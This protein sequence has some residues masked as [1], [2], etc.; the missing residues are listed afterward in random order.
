MAVE[1]DFVWL[2]HPETG[3]MN[4][5]PPAA[6]PMWEVRGWV[7]CDPPAEDLSYLRDPGLFVESEPAAAPEH[8]PALEAKAVRRRQTEEN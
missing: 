3:G 2:R 6:V 7:R 5:F 8:P 1:N 4:A